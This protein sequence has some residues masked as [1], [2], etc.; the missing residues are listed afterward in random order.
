MSVYPQTW[1]EM[2]VLEAAGVIVVIV[3]GFVRRRS[4]LGRIAM[5][6]LHSLIW[7]ASTWLI[8]S[9]FW[10]GSPDYGPP[11]WSYL[12]MAGIGLGL[13]LGIPAL[14]MERVNLWPEK[15]FVA[16]LLAALA[17]AVAMA[18]VPVFW[19]IGGCM[20]FGGGCP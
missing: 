18:A 17:G 1:T 12:L 9:F 2:F 11:W 3:N 8:Y 15:R 13:I 5:W 14:V 4:R 19:V 10:K 6:G 16:A 7:A 20:L